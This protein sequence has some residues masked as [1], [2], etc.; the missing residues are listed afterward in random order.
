MKNVHFAKYL[1]ILVSL[2]S[3]SGKV[4]SQQLSGKKEAA[5]RSVMARQQADWNKGD[6]EGFMHGYW[7]SD[8]LKFIGKTGITYGWQATLDRY[9][10]GYPDQS[11][12]GTLTFTLLH[13]EKLGPKGAF[14]VGKWELKR[15]EDAPQGHFSLVWR[16]VK[17][18]WV[19][20]ADHSS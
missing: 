3:F 5:I 8:S 4:L 1:I 17:G 7:E 2:L 6:L 11:A 13:F 20:I 16:K 9:K 18:E 19:I 14:V 12:M 15:A 10:R